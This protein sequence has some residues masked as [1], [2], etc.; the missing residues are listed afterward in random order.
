[1]QSWETVATG[2]LMGIHDADVISLCVIF[3]S[4]SDQDHTQ[5]VLPNPVHSLLSQERASSVRE[6]G[7]VFLLHDI[8]IPP[9]LG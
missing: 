7:S 8:K 5:P 9:S 1:M 6:P 4:F 2:A 3:L